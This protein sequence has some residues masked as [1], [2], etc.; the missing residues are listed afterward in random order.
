MIHKEKSGVMK[1]NE[2]KV[3]RFAGMFAIS[4]FLGISCSADKNAGSPLNSVLSL[5]GVATDTT[6]ST[7]VVAPYTETDTPTS[8]PANFGAVA[9]EA[10]LFISSYS[11]VDRYK[12][13]EIRFSHPMNKATVQADLVLSPSTGV[14]A[15]PGK[16]GEFYWASSSRLVFDPYR[17]FKTNEQYTFSLTNASKTIDGQSLTSYSQTFKT[18]PDYLMTNKI[19]TTNVLGGTND[20]TFNKATTPTLT[21]TSTFTNPVAGANSIQSIKLKHMG[22][23]NTAGITICSSSGVACDMTATINTNLSASALPPFVG[24]NVYYYEITVNSGKVFKRFATFN[25]GNVNTT[26]NNMIAKGGS[27]ILD[28]AQAMPFLSKVLER[29]TAGNFKVTNQTF[30]QFAGLPITTARRSGYCID[31]N[32]IGSFSM[33]NY[34]RNYG[35]AATGYGDGYCGP[36]G[37]EPGGFTQEGCAT[38]IFTS[39]TDFDIDVYITGINVY[40]NVSGYPALQNIGVSMVANNTGELGFNFKGKTLA[41]DMVMIARS[42]GS[43]FLVIGAGNRF[44]FSTT[45]YLNYNDA[46]PADRST[47][48]KASLTVDTNGDASLNIFTPITDLSNFNT[49]DWSNNLTVKDRD[50]RVNQVK[51][52]ATTSGLAGWLAGTTEGAANGMVPSLTPLITRS[53]LRNF[54]EDVAPSVLN[55]IIGSLKNPGV[56][57]ALPSYLPAPLANFPLNVKIQLGSDSEVRVTGVNKG[58]VGSIDLGITAAS[59]IGSPR[60]HQLTTG[61]VVSK[62]TGPMSNIYQ[63]SK[64]AANPGLLLS[65]TV[66]SITQ[67]AYHLWKNRALDLNIDKG[68]IDT[69]KL[70]AGTDPL[71]QLT[72][73]L[74]KVS[75]IINIL[76]PGRSQLIGINPTT[77]T[78]VPAISG[79]D[80]IIIKVDPIQAPNGTLKPVTGTAK[81]KLE[82][83]FTDIQLSILGKRADNS[84]YL[85]S[86]AR[87][88]LK[89]IADFDFVTF[90][91]PTNNP[92]Y[93][94]LNALKI[95]ISNGPTLS[96]TL[97]I[98]EGSAGAGAPN[99]F[100]LDPKGIL[101][102]VD[103]LV[104]SL[105][106]PLVNN[107]LKEIPLPA[108]ISLP[109]LTNPSNG[110]ACGIITKTTHSFLYTLPIADTEPYPYVF[111]GLRL[112]AGGPAAS[113]PGVLITCP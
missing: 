41:V 111:G 10:V 64:S 2:K 16:G 49:T 113:D 96:Y 82:V 47:I 39:C 77:G 15:G 23:T 112:T 73:S 60:T 87:A 42:R 61:F 97:D 66:D 65:L 28:Q 8:L 54:I 50:G 44:V 34:I 67:A 102:V 7:N 68:F 69:I 25:Y 74:I 48:G 72:E 81:P 85:I 63:F 108:S 22:D 21:L 92:A 32:G 38:L 78:L 1:M 9:P 110:N 105:I 18:E 45:A 62:P 17:E 35:D 27:I 57:I 12:S 14:L 100:G 109:A 107:V 94:N 53:M 106:V 59:P 86:T 58:I 101:A 52:E 40:T 13:I 3:L 89:G 26:P 88:S 51:L 79:T 104:P 29:F 20:V 11:D 33:P 24:G 93:A 103:P 99:P 91:N 83:N 84:T 71:F 90:S 31:Y 36:A 56:N 19:N 43:L 4:I 70:Y 46:P 55:S 30:N 76:A 98:L 5:F 80:D 37:D 95:V 75:P 6:V